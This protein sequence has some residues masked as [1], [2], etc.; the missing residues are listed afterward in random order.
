VINTGYFPA[1]SK[2]FVN[3]YRWNSGIQGMNVK[4]KKRNITNNRY[5]CLKKL[6]IIMA[7][8][9]VSCNATKPDDCHK[10]KSS[11]YKKSV[12]SVKNTGGKPIV[13][14]LQ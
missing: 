11:S 1:Q 14:G 8:L 5:T 12:R 9:M 13:K 4:L 10:S 3:S 7:V 2:I 6:I